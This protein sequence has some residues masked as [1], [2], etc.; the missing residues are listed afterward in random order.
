MFSPKSINQLFQ[1]F[2]DTFLIGEYESVSPSSAVGDRGL[3]RFLFDLL[4]S[5]LCLFALLEMIIGLPTV[6][7]A[8]LKVLEVALVTPKLVGRLG[9]RPSLSKAGLFLPRT[10]PAKLTSSGGM[11]D[12]GI[13]LLDIS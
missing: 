6:E 4:D 12:D 10:L 9:C 13:L 2:L 1:A 5:D 8:T 11:S 7:P 3:D